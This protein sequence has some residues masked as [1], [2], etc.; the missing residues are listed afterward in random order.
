[1]RK[2]RTHKRLKCISD[3]LKHEEVFAVKAN[4]P[5][6]GVSYDQRNTVDGYIKIPLSLWNYFTK[7][8]VPWIVMYWT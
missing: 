8:M 4:D 5:D 3:M 6:P 2:T 7:R 1:M